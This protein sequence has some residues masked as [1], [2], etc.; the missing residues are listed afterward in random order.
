MVTYRTATALHRSIGCREPTKAT[1]ILRGLWMPSTAGT[2][3]AR[4][5]RADGRAAGDRRRNRRSEE[6]CRDRDGAVRFGTAREAHRTLR[7]PNRRHERDERFGGSFEAEHKRDALQ[8]R[9]GELEAEL[10]LVKVACGVK[11]TYWVLYGLLIPRELQ[12]RQ[13]SEWIDV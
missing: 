7:M 6:A 13:R 2:A 12:L 5:G 4:A 3:R 1:R 8:K 11:G 9:I 10:E